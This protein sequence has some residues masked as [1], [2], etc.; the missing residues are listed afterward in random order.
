MAEMTSAATELL[1]QLRGRPVWRRRPWTPWP[2]YVASAN[3]DSMAGLKSPNFSRF[4]LENYLTGPE[5]NGRN[6]KISG[7]IQIPGCGSV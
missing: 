2:D 7:E 5:R 1:N 4:R 3:S 6:S